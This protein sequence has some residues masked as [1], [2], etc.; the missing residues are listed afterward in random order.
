MKM[1]KGLKHLSYED[2]L[3]ELGLFSL[4]KTTLQDDL[5]AAF[6]YIK[7]AYRKAE[8]GL[9]TMPCSDRIRRNGF[10]L[11]ESRFKLDVGKTF[12]TMIGE[13]L[14]QVTQESLEVQAG[15]S[16]EHHI[17]VEGVPSQG[18]GGWN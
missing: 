1:I 15:W 6:Q 5:I 2:I 16:S 11:K 14:A 18:S 9:L 7:G 17:P 13:T 3:R 8:E 12:L 10:K 4:E